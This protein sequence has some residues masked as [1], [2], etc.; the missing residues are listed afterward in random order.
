[1]RA[2]RFH[3]YRFVAAGDPPV[4]VAVESDLASWAAEIVG[5]FVVLAGAAVGAFGIDFHEADG[6]R[7]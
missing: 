4:E 2:R 5:L 6:V 1:M 7:R 3:G